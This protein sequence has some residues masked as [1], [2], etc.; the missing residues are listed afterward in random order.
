MPCFSDICEVCIAF[1][2]GAVEAL[3]VKE[4]ELFQILYILAVDGTSIQ[5]V[6]GKGIMPLD[7]M[8]TSFRTM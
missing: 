3:E 1:K 5:G 4:A 7:T 2:K 6:N 8:C